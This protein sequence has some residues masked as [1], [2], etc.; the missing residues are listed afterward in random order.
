MIVNYKIYGNGDDDDIENNTSCSFFTQSSLTL[1]H[2]RNLFPYE[3]IF[4]FRAKVIGTAV[5]IPDYDYVWLD[6][7][8]DNEFIPVDGKILEIRVIILQINDNGVI[9]DDD[10]D[11]EKEEYLE[12][13]NQELGVSPFD[14]PE[15][16]PINPPSKKNNNESNATKVINKLIPKGVQKMTKAVAQNSYQ[17]VTSGVSSLW[18]NIKNTAQTFMQQQS[19]LSDISEE[20]LAELSEY[21]STTFEDHNTEHVKLMK[22]MFSVMFPSKPYNRN[23]LLWKEAGWQ[24]ADPVADLKGFIICIIN[25][26]FIYFIFITINSFW[27]ISIESHYLFLSY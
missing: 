27:Y 8:D 17:T 19:L 21:L 7:I 10:D 24:K 26:I 9:D 22:E 23:S 3:G 2:I 11:R 25:I 1:K 4:H 20:R 13:I 6:L 18:N 12:E 16:F 14:R 15:R 5:G